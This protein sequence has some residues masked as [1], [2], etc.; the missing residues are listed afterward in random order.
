MYAHPVLSHGIFPACL[1]AF[2]F[3]STLTAHWTGRPLR[4][5]INS[6]SLLTPWYD[7]HRDIGHE[8][9][10]QRAKPIL[11]EQRKKKLDWTEHRNLRVFQWRPRSKNSLKK[12]QRNTVEL[13][14]GGCWISH[15]PTFAKRS[16][17][18]MCRMTVLFKSTARSLALIIIDSELL[19]SAEI[20]YMFVTYSL[21][22]LHNFQLVNVTAQ[23]VLCMSWFPPSNKQELNAAQCHMHWATETKRS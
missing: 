15:W 3:V 18:S 13:G 14:A 1:W 10:E 9:L 6:G 12:N 22:L 7:S 2:I 17:D 19:A 23:F 16:S 8:D 5:W 11:K 21:V 4:D 20:I